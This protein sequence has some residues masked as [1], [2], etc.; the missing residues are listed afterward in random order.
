MS[1]FL[2][3]LIERAAGQAPMLQRR[4]RAL[5]ESTE[6][7]AAAPDLLEAEHDE[8]A[9]GPLQFAPDP[10]E[11]N[12]TPTVRME[13]QQPVPATT[14]S[15]PQPLPATVPQVLL[16]DRGRTPQPEANHPPARRAAVPRLRERGPASDAGRMA[17]VADS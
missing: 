15:L 5:F 9:A 7:G 1:E 11:R 4:P 2:T 13:L 16:R 8:A 12:E 3:H 10:Q 17:P 6:P 14:N